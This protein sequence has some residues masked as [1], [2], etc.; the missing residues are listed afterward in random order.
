VHCLRVVCFTLV[1]ILI[2]GSSSVRLMIALLTALATHGWTVVDRVAAGSTKVSETI[3]EG[4]LRVAHSL[5]ETSTTSCFNTLQR[6]R[7]SHRRSS[8]CQSQVS[9]QD[10]FF[11]L[12]YSTR[13]IIR[14]RTVGCNQENASAD[15]GVI[16]CPTAYP[17]SSLHPDVP[18]PSSPPSAAPSSPRLLRP[19][20]S[21]A[22]AQPV[23]APQ[24]TPGSHPDLSRE[25]R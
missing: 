2:G 14:T 11:P 12:C 9:A 18:P 3:R 25:C 22:Q 7:Q 6:C 15:P 1:A 20:N 24:P 5:S 16:Q 8:P 21:P 19:P 4:P 17:S 10:T 23:P 13:T